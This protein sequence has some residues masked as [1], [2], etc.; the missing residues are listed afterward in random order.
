MPEAQ[1]HQ[2]FGSTTITLTKISGPGI[3]KI[4]LPPGSPAL[5]LFKKTVAAPG[6]RILSPVVHLSHDH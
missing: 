4:L 1:K 2:A 3:S 5:F 6:N